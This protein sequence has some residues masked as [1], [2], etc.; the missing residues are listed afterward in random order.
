MEAGAWTGPVRVCAHE[1]ARSLDAA[2]VEVP[3][4]TSSVWEDTRSRCDYRSAHS[5]CAFM[6][7]RSG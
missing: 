7:P 4:P 3:V 5:D 1:A 6:E 2:A